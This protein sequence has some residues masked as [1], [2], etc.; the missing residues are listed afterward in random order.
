MYAEDR[1]QFAL[2]CESAYEMKPKTK[3]EIDDFHSEL[4]LIKELEGDDGFNEEE[5]TLIDTIKETL[6]WV[7][8]SHASSVYDFEKI[9]KKQLKEKLVEISQLMQKTNVKT[10]DEINNQINKLS[11]DE[12]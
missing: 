9:I 10:F 1:R 7:L 11:L 6:L 4:E 12:N 3:E 2:T 5:L 8:G